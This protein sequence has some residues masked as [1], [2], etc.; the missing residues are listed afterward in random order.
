MT[1]IYEN[2]YI[3]KNSSTEKT[4]DVAFDHK[5]KRP[6]HIE[7]KDSIIMGSYSVIG[8]WLAVS[9]KVDHKVQSLPRQTV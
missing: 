2:L 8:H 6:G 5:S 7:L 9:T 1:Y 3:N 4:A